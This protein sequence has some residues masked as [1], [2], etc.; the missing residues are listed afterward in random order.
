M[1]VRTLYL[2]AVRAGLSPREAAN[3]VAF[4]AGIGLPMPDKG[5]TIKQ[6]VNLLALK[7]EVEHGRIGG[8]ER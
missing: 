6:V 1:P 8:P 3:L 5:W 7:W 2:R 4:Q